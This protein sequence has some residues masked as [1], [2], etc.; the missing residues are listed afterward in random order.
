VNSVQELSLE[1]RTGYG[2]EMDL[3]EALAAVELRFKQVTKQAPPTPKPDRETI[4]KEL[5]PKVREIIKSQE[6][7]GWWIVRQDKF[8][9]DVTGKTWNGEYRVEDRISSALFNRNVSVLCDFL[10]AIRQE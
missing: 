9:Q 7:S 1:R 6:K 4:L 8:R 10:E 2:Y 5:A 3:T